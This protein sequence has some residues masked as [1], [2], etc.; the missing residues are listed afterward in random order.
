MNP[1]QQAIMQ[2]LGQ[3][4]NTNTW[5]AAVP[6]DYYATMGQQSNPDGYAMG[7]WSADQLNYL[8]LDPTTVSP[9]TFSSAGTGTGADAYNYTTGFNPA[10]TQALQAKGLTPYVGQGESG[11]ASGFFDQNGNLVGPRN[12]WGTSMDDAFGVGMLAAGALAGGAIAAAPTAAGDVGMGSIGTAGMTPQ[13]I[14]A[15]AA[16]QGG[17]PT[18]TGFSAAG[19]SGQVLSPSDQAFWSNAFG[20]DAGMNASMTPQQIEAAAGNAASAG[21]TAGTLSSSDMAALYGGTGYG[22]MVS[23]A[24]LAA[25]SSWL[26][27]LPSS[28]GDAVSWLQKNPALAGSLTSLINGGL[29][30]YAATK[31]GNTQASAA[32]NAAQLMYSLAQQTRADQAPWRTQGGNAVNTLGD[33]LGTSGNTSAPGYGSL[34]KQFTP[35]DLQTNL[36]P[37]YQFMLGQGLGAATN[38]GNASGFSGN[39]L[40]GIS[41]YATNYA[42]GAY[43]QAFDNW[44]TQQNQVYNRLSNLAGLG[45]TANQSTGSLNTSQMGAGGNLATSGAAASAA[46]TI[47]ATNAL[48]GGLS[49]LAGWNY[50]NSFTP[51]DI[52][53]KTDI[54]R[55]GAT[56]SGVPIYSYRYKA[57]G[58]TR[59][60]VMAQDVAQVAPE[61]VAR[62]PDGFLRVNYTRLKDI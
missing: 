42:Q 25:N 47:G 59:I 1:L 13:Q 6:A 27:S 53:L 48:T 4:Y 32:N 8:G 43:Q 15:A 60:G 36:A 50:L 40:K 22:P 9:F 23:P 7:N 26:S 45:Q 38:A 44:N 19:A 46:G 16:A 11:Y 18:G 54:H 31:A 41:D 34:L 55:L 62:G 33:L 3:G 52:R 49:N 61:L 28:I 14:E 20:P 37:N 29:G 12:Q 30:A 24:E 51:S 56:D 57:G 58:G 17:V 35:A 21:S 10:F 2:A 5:A 39:T